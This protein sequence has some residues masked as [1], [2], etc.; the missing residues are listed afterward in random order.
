[1]SQSLVLIWASPLYPTKNDSRQLEWVNRLITGFT[2]I[3]S[4][5]HCAG[6]LSTAAKQ[7]LPISILQCRADNW[8]IGTFSTRP[9]IFAGI[10]QKLICRFHVVIKIGKSP[11]CTNG[12]FLP[13]LLAVSV[14]KFKQMFNP[15]LVR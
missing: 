4:P 5:Q 10:G 8:N 6:I 3:Q 14:Y 11:L 9:Q 12:F 15:L 2:T 1:M 13:I 7:Y